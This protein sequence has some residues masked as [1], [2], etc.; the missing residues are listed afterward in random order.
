MHNFKEWGIIIFNQLLT[1]QRLFFF[2]PFETTL[3][4]RTTNYILYNI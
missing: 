2:Y 3:P 1:F 4:L